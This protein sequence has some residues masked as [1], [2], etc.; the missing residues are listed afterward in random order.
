MLRTSEVRHVQDFLI[1]IVG[2]GRC[3]SD[4]STHVEMDF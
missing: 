1:F 3:A 4:F 2:D